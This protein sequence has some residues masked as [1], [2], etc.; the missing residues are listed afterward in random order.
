MASEL[1][2]EGM[3]SNMSTLDSS[4]DA[5]LIAI[6]MV[7]IMFAGFFRLDELLSKPPKRVVNGHSLSFWDDNGSPEC[8]EPDG[9]LYCRRTMTLRK[10]AAVASSLHPEQGW[11]TVYLSNED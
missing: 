7:L 8:I 6:P 3:F 10:P 2:R 11:R 9:T 5:L 4:R 1:R